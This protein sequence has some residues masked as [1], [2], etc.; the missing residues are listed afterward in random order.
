MISYHFP[1]DAAV[2]G[3]RVAKFSHYLRQLGWE[4]HVVTV[5]ERHVAQRD[6][7]R[8][9][10]VVG[11]QVSRTPVWPT[12]PEVALRLRR[13][14]TGGPTTEPPFQREPGVSGGA[15]QD[16]AGGMLR[17]YVL[18]LGELPD[19]QIGWL[20]PAAW[21]AWRI[22]RRERI[23]LVV[24]SSPP[25]TTALVGL[26]L[27]GLPGIRVVT[28]LR[29]P[30]YWP[31][32]RPQGTR[33]EMADRIERRL[34]RWIVERSRRVVT[35]TDHY[36]EALRKAYPH[37][38]ADRIVTIWNGY[39]SED[40]RP[41]PRER[42]GIRVTMAYFGAFYFRRTPREFLLALADLFAE[43]ALDRSQVQVRFI[44]DVEFADGEPVAD[45]VRAAGLE[46]C[47]RLE[48]A[49]PREEALQQMR[50]ADVLLLFAPA[51]PYS[52]PA[53][54]FEYLGAGR[55]ILCVTD[56]GATA[57]LIRTTGAGI[58]VAPGD[59]G[60]IRGAIRQLVDARHRDWYP[61]AQFERGL[62]AQRFSTLL[63]EEIGAPVSAGGYRGT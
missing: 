40:V 25:R 45:L 50:A 17:R 60:A 13:R 20:L 22:L 61:P 28:D 55:P 24:T 62:L 29:D 3:V 1:P 48:P 4:V 56:E 54:T 57:D 52:I 35:T 44:G 46:C 7:G 42:S 18:S 47:V 5:A 38:P 9:R 30:W 34:E 19:P 51:Q 27:S 10:D 8:L 63:A 14:W 26:L 31:E 15:D 49:V 39:D 36:S 32:L 53:K 41:S 6:E 43:R 58:V 11:C 2:G 21:G 12:V 59:V 37:V 16:G 23:H 33:T